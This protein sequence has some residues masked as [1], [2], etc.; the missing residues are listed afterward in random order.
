LTAPSFHADRDDRLRARHR[1]LLF[2]SI[3]AAAIAVFALA[4]VITILHPM[5]PRTVTMATGHE[6]GAYH[7]FGKRYREIFARAGIDLRLA[8]SA[9]ALE[10]LRRLRDP[11]SGVDVGF[12]Q[13]GT[14]SGDVPDLVS[15][16]TVS[17]EPLWLFH[18]GAS[19]G[20][21]LEGLR[22]KRISIGP[23]GSGTRLL[24]TELLSR[25]G[26]EPGIAEFLPLPPQL[27][28]EKLLDGQIH[29]ALM[30]ASWE[31]PVVRRL[32][33]SDSVELVSFARA[34]ALVALY[35]YLNKLV[36]PAGVADLGR[37]RPPADVVVLAPETSL[38]VR[39]DLH[40]AIQYLLLDAATEVHSAPG[41]FRKAGQFPAA[42]SVDFPLSDPARHFY[43]SGRPFLQRYLPFWFAVL[44]GQALVL[45]IPVAAAVYP[46]MRAIPGIYMWGIRYRIF[47]LYGELKFLDSE[48]ERRAAAEDAGDLSAQLDRLEERASHLHVPVMYTQMLFALRRDINLVRRRLER[49]PDTGSGRQPS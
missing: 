48:V 27:A 47:R 44:V 36:V 30:V 25:M 45:L 2:A 20:R 19:P 34:D 5:P 29:A 10:N 4:W 8:P 7:E 24:A 1:R 40:P 32:L 28:M 21:K 14:V 16:G 9:G 3:A 33:A 18:R 37:N 13:G 39:R 22:G 35:P 41:I 46:L 26:V 43:K 42:E 17:Y 31:S 23:E 15:L 49:P 38:L 6:G 12:A 11:R